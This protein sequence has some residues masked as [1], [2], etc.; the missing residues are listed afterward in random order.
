MTTQDG[1][2]FSGTNFGDSIVQV[3]NIYLSMLMKNLL[4]YYSSLGISAD[5]NQ[6]LQST[7]DDSGRQNIL[8]SLSCLLTYCSTMTEIKNNEELL[9]RNRDLKKL[10]IYADSNLNTRD[11]TETEQG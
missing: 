2:E 4:L 9:A 3:G 6:A 1:S 8:S 5:P 10:G 11:L 7:Q